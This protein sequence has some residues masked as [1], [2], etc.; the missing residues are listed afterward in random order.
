MSSSFMLPA[1]N[2]KHT[3]K[4]GNENRTATAIKKQKKK[5]RSGP[6]VLW[7]SHLRSRE[8]PTGS[9]GSSTPKTSTPARKSKPIIMPACP[10][11]RFV[12]T[13]NPS[14]RTPQNPSG[15]AAPH[16]FCCLSLSPL[17]LPTLHRD[18]NDSYVNNTDRRTYALL[19]LL[20][21]SAARTGKVPRVL[22][23]CTGPKPMNQHLPSEESLRHRL[24]RSVIVRDRTRH[25]VFF[26]SYE[27]F[28]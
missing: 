6:S 28:I 25:A 14:L 11:G 2:K 20:R 27:P 13:Q 26:H 12:R 24:H 7:C 17:G 4:K 15:R 9:V 5:K 16:P 1:K 3:Q 8:L 18:T 21:G 23:D 22:W 19:F 10:R